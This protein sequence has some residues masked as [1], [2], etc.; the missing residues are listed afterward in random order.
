MCVLCMEEGGGGSWFQTE[1]NQ[2]GG[3]T[4]LLPL[5]LALSCCLPCACAYSCPG[6]NLLA[7]PPAP[8]PCL[9]ACL[10][11]HALS[12]SLPPASSPARRSS[13]SWRWTT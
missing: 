7:C 12:P 5:T 11:A 6:P 4:L 2:A 10:P 13:G 8:V 3:F 1:L 9:P